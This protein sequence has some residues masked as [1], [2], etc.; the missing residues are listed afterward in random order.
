M[1]MIFFYK[2]NCFS[3]MMDSYPTNVLIGQ[4][5]LE[6]RNEG[7]NRTEDGFGKWRVTKQHAF[8]H[9]SVQCY[10]RRGKAQSRSLPPP[11]EAA[12]AVPCVTSGQGAPGWRST[13]GGT[14]HPI[15]TDRKVGRRGI[16]FA[17]SPIWPW[18]SS[19][20]RTFYCTPAQQGMAI[21]HCPV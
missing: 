7:K 15:F 16:C 11:L 18:F 13:A 12:M 21:A 6:T 14:D 20:P 17:S 4:T 19:L 9:V 5:Q 2:L 3:E 1:E 8:Q 10:A